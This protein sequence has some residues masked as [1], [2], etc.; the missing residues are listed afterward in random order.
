MLVYKKKRKEKRGCLFFS[1]N[2][3]TALA[4]L[5][6]NVTAGRLQGRM[7]IFVEC[8]LEDRLDVCLSLSLSICPGGVVG[9]GSWDVIWDIKVPFL[10]ERESLKGWLHQLLISLK[11]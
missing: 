5:T 10:E 11:P 8:V 2:L 9:W 6:G 1:V 4:A 7:S 3:L